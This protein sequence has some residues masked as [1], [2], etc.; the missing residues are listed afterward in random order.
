[1]GCSTAT[2]AAAAAVVNVEWLAKKEMSSVFFLCYK[3]KIGNKTERKKRK[4]NKTI[5]KNFFLNNQKQA[6]YLEGNSFQVEKYKAEIRFD[7]RLQEWS[8][9]RGHTCT[10]IYIMCSKR[11]ENV[12][13]L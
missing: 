10:H 6:F 2:V 7:T 5:I 3:L 8:I 12:C 9:Y 1:M 13:I 11:K 4:K